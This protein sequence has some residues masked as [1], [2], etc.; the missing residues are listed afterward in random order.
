MA[1]IAQVRK[2]TAQKTTNMEKKQKKITSKEK[3]RE[4]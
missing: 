3:S 2:I 1:D 4:K